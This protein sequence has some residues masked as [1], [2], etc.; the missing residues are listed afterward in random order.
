MR[1]AKIALSS[2]FKTPKFNCRFKTHTS[3]ENLLQHERHSVSNEK[4]I[5]TK[6]G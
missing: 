6:N 2:A 4:F 1:M 5:Y 3:S